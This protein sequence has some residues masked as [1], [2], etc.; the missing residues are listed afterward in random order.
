MLLAALGGDVEG[1][2]LFAQCV[3]VDAQDFGG[4]DLI[5][6]GFLQYYINQWSFHLMQDHFIEIVHVLQ[7][8][9]RQRTLQLL[10]DQPFQ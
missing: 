9:L 6:P 4:L 7:V 3:A 1:L 5:P 10:I 2:D 8:Y